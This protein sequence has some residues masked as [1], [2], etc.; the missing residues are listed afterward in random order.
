[1][2]TLGT[3]KSSFGNNSVSPRRIWTKLG[4]NSS[5][6]HPGASHTAQGPRKQPEILKNL[7]YSL[8][9]TYQHLDFGTWIL[10]FKPLEPAPGKKFHIESD[11]DVQIPY[12]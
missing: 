3:A 4:G 10:V 5:Y 8:S 6:K 11:S 12:V 7:L 2:E 9:T 1:M